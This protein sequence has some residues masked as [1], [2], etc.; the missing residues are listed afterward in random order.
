MNFMAMGTINSYAKNYEQSIK[1][2]QQMRDFKKTDDSSETEKTQ[3]GQMLEILKSQAEGDEKASKI[4]SLDA[5]LK[6]G[7]A[8]TKEELEYL[9]KEMPELYEEAKIV[10]AEREAY[11]QKLKNAKSKDD[12]E[13]I[14]QEKTIEFH[15]KVKNTMNNPYLTD[16]KKYRIMM[17]IQSSLSAVTDSHNKF[18]SSEQYSKLPREDEMKTEKNRENKRKDNEDTPQEKDNNFGN[19]ISDS[20]IS[21]ETSGKSDEIEK[22]PVIEV[23]HTTTQKLD[24]DSYAKLST[25]IKT[26]NSILSSR[27][28]ARS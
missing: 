1:I 22:E 23:A 7:Q 3:D 21:T 2:N 16:E 15:S 28:I 6:S 25:E 24:V 19:H 5:K 27:L 10:E 12:V 14:Q 20:D 8:L 4:G 26:S 13:K 18:L 17:T 11:E 9:K